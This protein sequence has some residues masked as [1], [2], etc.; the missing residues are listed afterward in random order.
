M[1]IKKSEI[2]YVEKVRKNK[3]KRKQ[4][5]DTKCPKNI[6]SLENVIYYEK[7]WNVWL[8]SLKNR[9][10]N[11]KTRKSGEIVENINI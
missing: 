5:N 8:K 1:F 10:K 6:W 11:K 9:K 4:R 3:T 7:D 2:L